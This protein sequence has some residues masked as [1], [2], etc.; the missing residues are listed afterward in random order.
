MKD[1]KIVK[2]T[3]DSRKVF[4]DELNKAI[5]NIEETISR[6]TY[7]KNYVDSTG[8]SINISTINKLNYIVYELDSM[9]DE[10]TYMPKKL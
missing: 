9:L 4:E 5:G 10:E 2:Q 8:Y 3:N 1:Y 7:N 6:I